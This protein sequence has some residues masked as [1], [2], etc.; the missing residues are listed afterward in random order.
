MFLNVPFLISTFDAQI[1]FVIFVCL[2]VYF[3]LLL[4]KKIIHLIIFLFFYKC[5]A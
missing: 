2:F 3:I 4:F 1:I 5:L